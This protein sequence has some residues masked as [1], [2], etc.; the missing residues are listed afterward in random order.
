MWINKSTGNM[1]PIL[2]NFYFA[3]VAK[4]LPQFT[5]NW[6]VAY[7][8][9]TLNENY[10]WAAK[11]PEVIIQIILTDE[12]FPPFVFSYTV[13]PRLTATSLLRPLYFVPAKRPYIFF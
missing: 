9:N 10:T 11:Q 4:T 6:C 12:V 13:E 8:K 2:L 5:I 3:G 7:A 1:A